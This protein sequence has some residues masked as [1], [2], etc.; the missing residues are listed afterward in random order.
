MKI[1][2]TGICGFVG[3]A[4]ADALLDAVEDLTVVGIDNL[5]RPGSE[6]NRRR[7]VEKRVRLVHGDLRMASDLA[8]LPA[9]DWVVDAA[10]NPSVLAGL[11][12]VSSSRQLFEHNL[13]GM[14]NLLEYCKLTKAGLLLLSSSRVYSL[15]ALAA[16]PLKDESDAFRLELTPN[17]PPGLS[18][19]GIGPAFSTE[20]PVSLY[21]STKLASEI[22]ALEYGSAFG[23]PVWIT[24]C[25]V[26]AGAGQFG[27][28]SQGVFAY[29]INAHLRR[30]PLRF[31]GFGGTGHQVRDAFHP[32]DLADLMLRQTKTNRT[33]GPRIYTAGGG[34]SNALSLAQLTRWCDDRFGPHAPERDAS[35][36]L[37]DIPWMVMDNREAWND[38]GWA[39]ASSMESICTEIAVHAERNPE[40]L[41]LS[42][43]K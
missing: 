43:A 5:I 39:P 23:F 15:A 20:P 2:I 17:P 35:S 13:V 25:G 40:W 32:R 21:G 7:L 36:R 27:T 30:Q 4:L 24:R 16:V 10:A 33:G 9:V 12:G 26:L 19:C 31:L 3:S 29:W 38:F 34:P 6:I 8:M 37:F 1:L 42:A 14:L 41:E 18:E 11:D 22:V 28:A